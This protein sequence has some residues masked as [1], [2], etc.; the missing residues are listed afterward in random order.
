MPEFSNSFSGNNSKKFLDEGELIRAI[1]FSIAA[2]YEA[3]QLYEQL[4]CSINNKMVKEVLLDIANEEQE[5]AGEFMK[6]LEILSPEEIKNYDA[7]K[8]EVEEKFM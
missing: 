3:I 4:A 5:H 6:I 7:G 8:S 1:R 2:E